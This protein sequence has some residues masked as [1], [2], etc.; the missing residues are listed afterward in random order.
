MLIKAFLDARVNTASYFGQRK[1]EPR[2]DV[3]FAIK[4]MTGALMAGVKRV[5][6]SASRK[7]ET[8]KVSESV[9]FPEGPSCHTFFFHQILG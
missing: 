6:M 4:E 9:G 1:R 5:C 8:R 3:S 7:R 2:V